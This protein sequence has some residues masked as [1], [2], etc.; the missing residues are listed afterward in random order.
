MGDRMRLSLQ[1]VGFTGVLSTR[2]LLGW[3][4]FCTE[5]KGGV[6]ETLGVK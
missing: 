4:L 5:E 3:V 2:L 1:D 6:L